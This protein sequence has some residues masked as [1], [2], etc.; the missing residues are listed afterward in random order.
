MNLRCGSCGNFL[1]QI[2]LEESLRSGKDLQQTMDD[3]GY[4][5]LCCRIEIGGAVPIVRLQKQLEREKQEEKIFGQLTVETTGN[6]MVG[7]PRIR[8]EENAPPGAKQVSGICLTSDPTED[9]DYEDDEDLGNF[10]IGGEN[11]NYAI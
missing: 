8:I 2:D 11:I 1:I 10:D 4:D 6:L 3:L 9:P 7:Q 5:R